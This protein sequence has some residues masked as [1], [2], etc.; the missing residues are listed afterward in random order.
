LTYRR[1][2]TAVA[3]AAVVTLSAAGAEAAESA[4]GNGRG[5]AVGRPDAGSVGNA[6]GKQPRGQLPDAATDGNRGY[7]CDGNAGVGR[8]NPAHSGCD[9][10]ST[11]VN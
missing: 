7:E 1:L 3:T 2:I 9:G 11:G 4:N 5:A 10:G 8:G 6:D